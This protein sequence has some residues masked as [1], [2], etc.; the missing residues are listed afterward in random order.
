MSSKIHLI[1]KSKLK[2]IRN[3]TH[4]DILFSE[5]KEKKNPTLGLRRREK[6]TKI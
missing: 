5:S 1:K 2:G 3:H 6:V 4:S